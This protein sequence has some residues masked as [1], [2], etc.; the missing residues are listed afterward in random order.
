MQTTKTEEITND[1]SVSSS[2]QERNKQQK[3]SSGA[4]K[5]NRC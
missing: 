4:T 5:L 3:V 2:V 1:S